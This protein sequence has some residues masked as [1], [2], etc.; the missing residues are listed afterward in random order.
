MKMPYRASCAAEDAYDYL[1][2]LHD[3]LIDNDASEY[4]IDA[5]LKIRTRLATLIDH[6]DRNGNWLDLPREIN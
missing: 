5:V 6:M 1:T 3:Q 4:L 2:L